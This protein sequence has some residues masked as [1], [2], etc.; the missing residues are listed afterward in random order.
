MFYVVLL[1][2]DLPSIREGGQ[3]ARSHNAGQEELG[4]LEVMVQI[5][6]RKV[7]DLLLDKYYLKSKNNHNVQEHVEEVVELQENNKE[8]HLEC[9]ILRN[10]CQD[11]TSQTKIVRLQTYC[12]VRLQT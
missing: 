5:W 9:E 8:L 7:F 10:R 12:S 2:Y 3:V 6:R 11:G 1:K 4:G